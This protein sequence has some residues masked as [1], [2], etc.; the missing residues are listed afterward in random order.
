MQLNVMQT[1]FLVFFAIFW[2]GIFNA[3]VRWKAF[4]WSLFRFGPALRRTLVSFL[5]LNILPIVFFLF[6]MW[7]LA[8]PIPSDVRLFQYLRAVVPAFAIFGFYRIWL[9]VIEIWPKTFYA[10][11]GEVPETYRHFEPA[12]RQS[13]TDKS[14]D[15]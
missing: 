15:G 2:G 6:A 13:Y 9:G 5:I 7:A 12:F 1:I 14:A 8:K 4:H 3:Q 10:P 11:I